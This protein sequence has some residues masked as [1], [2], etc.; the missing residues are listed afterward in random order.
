MS[1]LFAYGPIERFA[2]ELRK[3]GYS[4]GDAVVPVPHQHHYRAEFDPEATEILR[5]LE[6]SHSPL[7]AQDEE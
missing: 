5:A 2:E 3:L 7:V 4:E 1:T 6:W